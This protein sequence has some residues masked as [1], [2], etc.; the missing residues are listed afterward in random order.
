MLAMLGMRKIHTEE[1]FPDKCF[2][3]KRERMSEGM[4]KTKETN[5]RKD[6]LMVRLSLSWDFAF[7]PCSFLF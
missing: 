4:L 2:G 1:K 6:L 5:V 3:R 7:G